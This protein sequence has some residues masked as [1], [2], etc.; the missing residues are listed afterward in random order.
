MGSRF[1]A[2]DQLKFRRKRHKAAS[3]SFKGVLLVLTLQTTPGSIV[4]WADR[5]ALQPRVQ[6]SPLVDLTRD[7]SRE[8]YNLQA[9]FLSHFPFRAWSEE[10]HGISQ[11]LYS[12]SDITASY[13]LYGGVSKVRT[14][15]VRIH[16]RPLNSHS[17]LARCT[18][19]TMI[20]AT[21]EAK[22]QQCSIRCI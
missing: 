16:S 19:A 3:F 11:I 9:T 10:S 18:K 17:C 15:L 8:I 7:K 5:E 22:V 13:C 6:S 12:R 14:T 1:F 21:R 4:T 2:I 20:S